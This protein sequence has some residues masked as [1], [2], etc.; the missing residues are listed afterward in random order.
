MDFHQCDQ[1]HNHIMNHWYEE[2]MKNNPQGSYNHNNPIGR[3]LYIASINNPYNY[4]PGNN[5]SVFD[6]FTQD[7]L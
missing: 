3:S 5:P 2:I 6:M 4:T 1:T 7:V